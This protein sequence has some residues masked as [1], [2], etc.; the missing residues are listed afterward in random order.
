[1]ARL[2]WKRPVTIVSFRLENGREIT[3]YRR[4]GDTLSYTLGIP[5]EEPEMEYKG[6][7]LA[8]VRAGFGLW[9]EGVGNLADLAAAFKSGS[10]WRT[11]GDEDR[12]TIAETIAKAADSSESHVFISVD[13][14]TGLVSQSVYI[15]RTD[16]REYTI[17]KT[18][19]RPINVSE[20]ELA[21]Y[22]SSSLTVLS[23]D[24][25]IQHY[26]ADVDEKG[27]GQGP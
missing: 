21:D 7:I 15:F 6:P 11:W 25:K 22:E 18:W 20:D 3:I 19:G 17:E 23:P 13:A 9:G 27:N 26:S 24:G 4:A 12:N 5:G 10:S 16:G 2:L 1:M 8:E 14:M